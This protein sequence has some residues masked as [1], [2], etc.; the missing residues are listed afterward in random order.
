[1]NPPLSV[2]KYILS[3]HPYCHPCHDEHSQAYVL[4][5]IGRLENGM[6][7]L[8]MW[9]RHQQKTIDIF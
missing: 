7:K 6:A 9:L 2:E 4:E 8:S 3:Q 1:M 5:N